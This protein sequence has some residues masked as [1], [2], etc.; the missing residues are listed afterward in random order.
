MKGFVNVERFMYEAVDWV[1]RLELTEPHSVGART[2][3]HFDA[4]VEFTEPLARLAAIQPRHVE[5]QQ[6]DVETIAAHPVNLQ[7]L[8]TVGHARDLETV[9]LQQLVDGVEELFVIIDGQH[10]DARAG[11][12]GLVAVWRRLHGISCSLFRR[13]PETSI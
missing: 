13:H 4:G 11:G 3:D 6:H 8:D 10:A 12:C 7:C 9:R 2:D 1:L 5:I